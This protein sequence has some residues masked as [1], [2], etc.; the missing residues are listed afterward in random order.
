MLLLALIH[1]AFLLLDHPIQH[2]PTLL[3][4][5]SNI[6]QRSWLDADCTQLLVG[7]K[8]TI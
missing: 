4:K 2:Q 6:S 7:L 3:R 5:V 8:K 1:H